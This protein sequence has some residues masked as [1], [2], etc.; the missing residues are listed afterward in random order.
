VLG[1]AANGP[2][3]RIVA[4]V[5]VIAVAALSTLLLVQTVVGWF[6]IA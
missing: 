5:S 1:A 3:F 4:G 2:T 6:G